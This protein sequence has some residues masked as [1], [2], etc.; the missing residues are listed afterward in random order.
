MKLI[1]CYIENFGKINKFTYNFSNGLNIVEE[2]NGW[3]K[4]TFAAFIKAMFYGLEY[5]K[6]GK[7]ITDRKR[8]MP[9]NRNKFGGYIVFETDGTEYKIERFFGNK[10]KEDTFT[11]YNMSKN[12]ISEDFGEKPG[13]RI[14]KVDRES[15]E[16]TAFITLDDSGLLN[17]II[18]TK[19]GNIEQK[20]ADLEKSTK[21][22]S[23]LEK[24]ILKIK[25]KKGSGGIL[26]EKR[27]TLNKLK[28]ELKNCKNSLIRIEQLEDWIKN[29]ED[30]LIEK[31]S[32]INKIEEEQSKILLYE[33]KQQYNAIITDFEIK[34]NLFEEYDNFFKE[35][36]MTEEELN[37]LKKE[38]SIYV[39]QKENFL[40]NEF[41]KEEG[42]EFE[43][44]SYKFRHD[45][46]KLFQIEECN[47]KIIGLSN[48]RIELK[49][50]SLTSEEKN[51]FTIMDN[52]YRN[53]NSDDITIDGYLDDFN[54]IT[55]I[56]QEENRI[57]IELGKLESKPENG[58]KKIK[59][60]KTNPLLFVGIGIILL[61]IFVCFQ[62]LIV[63]CGIVIIGL[64]IGFISGLLNSKNVAG[65]QVAEESHTRE[66]LYKSLKE[67]EVKKN[68][69]KFGYLSFFDK[70]GEKP[71][72]ILSSL[73]NCKVEISD[74]NRLKKQLIKNAENTLIIENE[75][76]KLNEEIQVFLGKYCNLMVM[77]DY[78]KALSDLRKRLSRFEVLSKKNELS[79]DIKKSMLE[80]HELLKGIFLHYYKEMPIDIMNAL[81][82]MTKKYY[83]LESAKNQ[84]NEVN[85]KKVKFEAENNVSIFEQIVLPDIQNNQLEEELRKQ[86][87]NLDNQ[88]TDKIKIIERYYKDINTLA[89]EADKIEDI[90][91]TINQLE[92]EVEELE[93][94]YKLLNLTKECMIEAKENLAQKY[95]GDLS[96]TFKKYL[97]ELNNENVDI[98]QMDI[99]LNVNVEH[100]GESHDSSE[101]SKGMK[102]LIQV[103]LRM[104]LVEAVYKDVEPP[105][106]ILDDPFVNLDNNRIINAT[107]LL[108][109]IST[110]YQIIYFI[111]HNSRNVL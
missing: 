87:S 50:F 108:R 27:D 22:L 9:W 6:T 43:E 17:D 12:T 69:L 93:C 78:E 30:N 102:D 67:Y 84:L 54:Q 61:G 59:K 105:I 48:K 101:L 64:I 7:T 96:N 94:Q 51:K 31:N 13:E 57:N 97:M 53:I 85:D 32:E 47:E 38:A 49:G 1:R 34:K 28:Q 100:E 5:K 74:Y 81:N 36:K 10:D 3:G 2:E 75:I 60:G 68:E 29:E 79:E 46:P 45:T 103:C 18:S 15:Y 76:S 90:D 107:R 44:L 4:T 110:K 86:K 20:E 40:K 58:N 62:S 82:E 80:S 95:M 89:L 25:A 83:D 21:A 66:A 91:A 42:Q 92:L 55:H 37:I 106:L 109:S 111:C 39:N 26:S 63:G 14:W 72:N 104:A 77:N 35:K 11:I 41:T 33:K 73:A 98:Y 70:I 56:E 24:E 23:L 88:K 99:N 8:Y 71:T 65:N 19:L 16:K 52:K